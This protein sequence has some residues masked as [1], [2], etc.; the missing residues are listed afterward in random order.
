MNSRDLKIKFTCFILYTTLPL[1][2]EV[3]E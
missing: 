1:E 2:I 3:E